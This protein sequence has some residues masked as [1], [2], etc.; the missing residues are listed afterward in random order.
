MTSDAKT[1]E[2]IHSAA[3]SLATEGGQKLSTRV[4]EQVATTAVKTTGTRSAAQAAVPTA[5]KV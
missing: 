2:Q 3:R 4:G 5:G 1:E